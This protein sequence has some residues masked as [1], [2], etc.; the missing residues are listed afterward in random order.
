[1]KLENS[2]DIWPQWYIG[3]PV[4]QES[5]EL[6]QSIVGSVEKVLNPD[7]FQPRKSDFHATIDY[8]TPEKGDIEQF[9]AAIRESYIQHTAWLKN[10]WV[11]PKSTYDQTFH[12]I[13]LMKSNVNARIYVCL[14]P[15]NQLSLLNLIG[16]QGQ[17]HISLWYFNQELSEQEMNTY[18]MVLK[19]VR[20]L[21][22]KKWK[23][24]SLDW[25][26]FDVKIK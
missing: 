21:H 17:A 18:S 22:F 14:V 5:V 6:L 9:V 8:Y 12:K 10:N 4:H 16:K 24:I 7:V 1:M 23:N 13:E 2:H 11:D 25:S 3:I 15:H 26:R 20:D 19:R